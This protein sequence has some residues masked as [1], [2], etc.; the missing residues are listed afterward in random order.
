[1]AQGHKRASVN[2][3]V[4]SSITF[5]IRRND[6]VLSVTSQHTIQIQIIQNST[7]SGKRS[8]LMGTECLNTPRFLGYLLCYVR[9]TA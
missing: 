6:A 5:S 8:V 9:D 1:M 2:A 4:V 7:E 3:M